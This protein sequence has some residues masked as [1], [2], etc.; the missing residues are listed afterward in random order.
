METRTVDIDVTNKH[1]GIS[2]DVHVIVT[3]IT[4]LWRVSPLPKHSPVVLLCR[5][6]SVVNL[7]RRVHQFFFFAF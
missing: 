4:V 6:Y 1:H 3:C 5:I 2:L 7:P